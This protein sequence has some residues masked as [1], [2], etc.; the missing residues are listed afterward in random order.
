MSGEAHSSAS[1]D[2]E[3]PA[4]AAQYQAALDRAAAYLRANLHNGDTSATG[5]G[6]PYTTL[7][8]A[9]GPGGILVLCSCSHAVGVDAFHAACVAGMRKAGRSGALIRSGRAGP[10]H[11]VHIGLPETGYLKALVF[12]LDE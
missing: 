6:M 12:R 1:R 3:T 8:F 5:D 11:P 9:T 7:G 4:K 2:G 10:D